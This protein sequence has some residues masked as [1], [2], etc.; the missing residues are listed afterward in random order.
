MNRKDLDRSGDSLRKYVEEGGTLILHRAR[1]EHQQW[2]ADFT[3][4]KVAVE[5]QPYHS[6]VDRQAIEK[7]EG[8]VQGLSNIDFYWRPNIGSESME[9]Q[10]Q[11][12]GVTPEGKGQVEHLVEVEGAADYLFPGGLV[13]LRMGK[14]KLII[15]QV[16][17]EV[18]DRQKIDYG[19]PM[20]VISMLLGNLGVVQ[21]LPAPKPQLPE[22]VT[23]E[24]LDLSKLANVG[25]RDDKAGSGSGWCDWGPEQ[26]IRDFPSGDIWLGA[27]YKVAKGAKNAVV[28]RVSPDHI[29][30]LANCPESVEI[31]VG[32]KRVAGVM[33]L[34]TGGWTTGLKPFGWRQVHY[35]DGTK[36]VMAIN[37]TNCA[38]WNYGHDD[39]P[40]EEGTTTWV[41]WSA[42]QELC[43][44]AGVRHALGQSAPREGNCQDR[45][46]QRRL[47]GGRAAFHRAPR[48]QPGARGRSQ[49][50]RPER[51][52]AKKSQ[53]LLQEA[54]TLRQAN[55]TADALAKLEDS[56]KADDQNVGSWVTL[57]EIHATTDGVEAFTALCKRWFAAL[58]KNYQAHNVLGKFLES[59]GRLAEALA[60]YK[61]SLELEWN[62]PPTIEAKVRLE[63]QLNQKQAKIDQIQPSSR[64]IGGK[65]T[66]RFAS[67]RRSQEHSAVL[68]RRLLTA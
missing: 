6:W 13:E 37:S 55:Q 16:K 24:T 38:D 32:K 40:D 1:P 3:G 68:V 31:P 62:Q 64:P 51:R 57:T 60:E 49:A 17:W 46:Y 39:F 4:R 44:H 15:D 36:E 11:V 48:R 65:S 66:R 30:Y 41:A 50:H 7:Y 56:L 8:L 67:P 47:A 12:S 20:R 19:S 18:P 53:A 43:D 61:R 9:S 52:D 27:P 5:V 21:R 54:L 2:L 14:G 23:Y 35:A 25:L 63:K 34:H 22:G 26:D 42:W 45:Y 58:P 10:W 59:K 28:L 33:F 29:K